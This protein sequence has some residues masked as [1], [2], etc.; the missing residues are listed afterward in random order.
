MIKNIQGRYCQ[1]I[2]YAI[3]CP[4][5]LIGKDHMFTAVKQVYTQREKKACF[6]V[7][8]LRVS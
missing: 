3:I 4:R 7:V 5:S 2:L 1:T 8:E 6:N